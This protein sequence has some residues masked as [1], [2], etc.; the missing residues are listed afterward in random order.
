M[1]LLKSLPP[2]MAFWMDMECEFAGASKVP[3]ALV[4]MITEAFAFK[5]AT[6]R[7]VVDTDV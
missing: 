2:R 1:M 6:K 4:R 7:S 3:F 5:L